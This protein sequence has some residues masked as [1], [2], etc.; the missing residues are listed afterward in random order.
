MNKNYLLLLFLAW[1]SSFT[2]AILPTPAMVS[3]LHGSSGQN[4]NVMLDWGNVTGATL[5]EYRLSLDPS[6]TGASNISTGTNSYVNTSNLFFGTSYY[7]AVRAKSATDSSNWSVIYQFATLDDIAM[8]GPSNGAI[9]QQINVMLDWGNVSGA[10]T[11]D[12]EIDTSADFNSTLRQYQS[13]P[14][15]NSYYYTSNL[16]FATKYYWRVRAINATDT[17]IWSSVWNFNTHDNITSIA[18]S[19]NTINQNVDVQLDWSS[20]TGISFYDVEIDTNINFNSPLHQYQSIP[21]SNSY[22]YTSNL[23]FSTKYYWRARARHSADTTSWTPIWNFTTHDNISL[24]TPANGAINQDVNVLLDWGTVSGITNYDVEIDTNANF[25]SGLHQYQSVISTYSYFNTSNLLFAT[26]YYWRA[27]ARHA[28]DTTT[29]STVWNFTTSDNIVMVSPSNGAINQDVNVLLDWGTVSGITNYDV[30]IDTNA[31]FN[32]GLHQYQSVISTYSY[33]NTSNLLFAT[34]YYWRARARHS[35]DTTTWSA[36]WNFTTKDGKPVHVSPANGATGVSLN[37]TIDWANVVGILGYHYQYSA[38][39]NFTTTLPVATGTTSQAGLTSLSYGESYYWRV[40]C[41]HAVDTSDWST[42]WKFTTLY[43]LTSPVQLSSPANGTSAITTS[44]VSLQWQSLATAV[45]YEYSYSTNASFVGAVNGTTTSLSATSSTLSQGITY[46]WKVRANNGSGYSPWSTV[47]SFTTSGIGTPILISPSNGAVN[48]PIV[49]L[50]LDW[51]DAS[52][53]TF[54]DY[55]YCTDV[56]FVSPAPVSSTSTASTVTISGLANNTTYYWRI[57]NNDGTTQSPWSTVWSFTTVGIGVPVLISPAN[58]AVGQPNTSLVLDWQDATSAVFYEYQYAT[59]VNFASPTSANTTVST[60]TLNGLAINTTYYWRVRTNYGAITSAWSMVW[61][62]TTSGLEIPV[63]VSPSNSATNQSISGLVL[64]W[65]N[66]LNTTYYEYQYSTDVNFVAPLSATSTVSSAIINGLSNN[67]TYYWRVRGNDG[68]NFSSWSSV[69][70]FSTVTTIGIQENNRMFSV[71]PN[72]TQDY[73]YLKFNNGDAKLVTLY[74]S[75][76]L[77]VWQGV[78]NDELLKIDL[79]S[80]S[81]GV[82]FVKVKSDV[83][84]ITQTVIKK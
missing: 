30:E 77:S 67:T 41:Y 76:G 43:Q 70:S 17:T 3:P 33:F 71:F 1:C 56:N 55:Q 62:F 39:S 44:T 18:P 9:F 26:K 53:G 45:F 20:A 66:T 51:Q 60:A 82:Y 27:R 42:P 57:R 24:L 46:Y 84:V 29:W 61:S 50:V 10:S 16:L 40:R 59:D 14:G 83:S 58:G 5:Y 15:S 80:L 32:S 63:L 73:I 25:N 49:S 72:P 21:G 65:N 52:G 38:D 34:K 75:L 12:L 69:W 54:Y 22:Y 4:V 13:I 31:N 78:S 8:V 23:R 64:D 74:N 36:V 79:T 68:N 19:N 37:P 35:S 11:F 2:Y 81:S 47:W 28:S 7:W 6:L 48:Q